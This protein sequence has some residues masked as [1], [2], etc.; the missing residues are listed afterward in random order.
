MPG[1]EEVCNDLNIPAPGSDVATLEPEDN[2]PSVE[3]VFSSKETPAKAEPAAELKEEAPAKEGETPEAV[4]DPFLDASKQAFYGEDGSLDS[5]KMLNFMDDKGGFLESVSYEDERLSNEKEA[6]TDPERIY[7]DSV[8]EIAND[9]EGVLERELALYSP[10]EVIEHL[11]NYFNQQR[12]AKETQLEKMREREEFKNEIKSEFKSAREE[13]ID[14]RIEIITNDLGQRYDNL[15]PGMQG[16]QVFEKFVLDGGLGGGVAKA[17][18]NRDNPEFSKLPESQ[19]KA[20][21]DQWFRK[22][23]SSRADMALAAEVGEARWLRSQ[24]PNIIQDAIKKG[25]GKLKM[26]TQATGGKPAPNNQT[27]APGMSSKLSE[28]LGR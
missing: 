16:K 2:G 7:S 15:I 24:L 4:A 14:A 26:H 11:K 1:I 8:L 3:D 20:A 22:F 28:F 10:E 6:A 25:A 12:T 17:L 19:Q 5:E 27:P 21:K 18:F 13:K 9:F 23:Q